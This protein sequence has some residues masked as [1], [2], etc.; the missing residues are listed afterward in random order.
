MR[1]TAIGAGG[2]AEKRA[3]EQ[4]HQANDCESATVESGLPAE[5][6]TDQAETENTGKRPRRR[7]RSANGRRA[8]I[9]GHIGANRHV[10]CGRPAAGKRN[11]VAVEGALRVL[12]NA[13]YALRNE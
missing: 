4:Q 10:D 12:W 1:V 9:D 7:P 2:D 13:R 11:R 8:H 5:H 3:S 6:Q